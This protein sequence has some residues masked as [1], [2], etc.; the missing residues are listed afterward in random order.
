M[1][2]TTRNIFIC[3][4]VFL[5]AVNV[6]SFFNQKSD[7]IGWFKTGGRVIKSEKTVVINGAQIPSYDFKDMVYIALEDLK[8]FGFETKNEEDR[9]ILKHTGTTY[10]PDNSYQEMFSYINETKLSR[11]EYTVEIDGSQI[12]GYGAGEYVIISAR[13]LEKINGCRVIAE[14]V[15]VIEFIIS[16]DYINGNNEYITAGD[17]DAQFMQNQNQNKKI[18]VLDPGHGMSS[19]IMSDEDKEYYGWVYNAQTGGWGEWRHWKSGSGDID[20]EGEGCSGRVPDG[21]ACWY[22][23]ENGD[24]DT[25]P[26]LN[27]NNALSAKKYLEEMG[28]I[29]RMTRTSNSEN[30]S[31]TQRIRNCYPDGDI[32]KAPDAN[33]YICIHSNAG[34]G[35]GS[36]YIELSGVY[37]QLWIPQNY[38]EQG[39]SLGQLINEK[40]IANTGLGAYG[41]GIISTMPE[42]ILFCKAPVVCGYLEIGFFDNQEDLSIIESQT[43]LVGKSIAEGI[44]NYY[45]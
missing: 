15:N 37:D 10:E 23:I 35:S 31:I 20:C 6:F 5:I 44:D 13:D 25:E 11:D 24:R 3:I 45:N 2:K 18:I 21:G 36:A 38:A 43:D 1:T 32:T 8:M 14:Q 30:P 16:N 34:G 28:Y 40:I 27:L 4:I 39:N 29:V 7:N 9:I 12:N 22:P 42:L 41:S 17:E 33:A 19:S 26:E